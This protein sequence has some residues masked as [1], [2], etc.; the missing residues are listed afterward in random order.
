MSILQHGLTPK[1][2]PL[3][4]KRSALAAAPYAGTSRV[5]CLI[6]RLKPNPTGD[7]LRRR[8][9]SIEVLGFGHTSA[10]GMKAGAVIDLTAAEAAIRQAVAL[11]ERTAKLQLEAVVVLVSAGR[12][13]SELISASVDVAGSAVS[14]GDIARVLSAGSRHMARAGRAVLHSLP[15]GYALDDAK[16]IRDPRGMMGRRL[17]IDMHVA[18]VDVLLLLNLML[19]VERCHLAVEALVAGPYV[20]G[21]S[22]LADDEADLGAAI[23]DMGAG[24]TGIAVF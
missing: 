1:M 3:S 4:P 19:A 2:R 5:A 7:T 6:G 12:P 11:A 13:A 15:I 14:D 24:T 22:A 10:R 16:C 8:T 21:L 18:S 20:A 23:V 17:G 9:H